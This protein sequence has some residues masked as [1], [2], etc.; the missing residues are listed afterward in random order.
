MYICNVHMH[1]IFG[2]RTIQTNLCIFY[3]R[4]YFF[5]NKLTHI[6]TIY[7]ATRVTLIYYMQILAIHYIY[8]YIYL[9]MHL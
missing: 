5:L 6:N 8:I 2:H 4:W 7:L 1:R 9:C 3:L